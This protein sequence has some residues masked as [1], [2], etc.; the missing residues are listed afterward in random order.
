MKKT[1]SMYEKFAVITRLI[2]LNA[3]IQEKYIEA[4][5]FDM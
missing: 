4:L 3:N 2:L 1:A 5:I